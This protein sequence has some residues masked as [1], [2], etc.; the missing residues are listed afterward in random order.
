M[1]YNPN[2]ATF[3]KTKK[4]SKK[5]PNVNSSLN[6]PSN[7]ISQGYKSEN[8]QSEK[9][10]NPTTSKFKS[11]TNLIS[12]MFTNI[13]TPVQKRKM[14]LDGEM[15]LRGLK[16]SDITEVKKDFDIEYDYGNREYKLKLCDIDEERIEELVTQ[17]KFR[18]EEG[19]G[20]CFYQLGVEDN[21]NPLG[22]PIEELELSVENLRRIVEKLDASANITKLHKG[23]MGFIAEV[24]I[25]QIDDSVCNDKLEI[26]VGLLGEEG[27]G[28]STLVN[29]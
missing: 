12:E 21:G 22:L 25:K 13:S 24:I 17:M 15:S 23:K 5:D 9:S 6:P 4:K 11:D 27:S 1:S 29:L 7:N 20:E 16:L 18:L 26:K 8:N 14:S 3:P 19:G 2:H 10:K 28:K